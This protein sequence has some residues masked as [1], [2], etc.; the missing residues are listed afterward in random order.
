VLPCYDVPICH[1][2]RQRV[3]TVDGT[4]VAQY[5]VIV[6]SASA[7]IL[8][9]DLKKNDGPGRFWTGDLRHV[10]TEVFGA[11]EAFSVGLLETTTRKASAPSCAV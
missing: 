11:F 7:F 8:A 10:K 2:S 3:I 1:D 9:S 6:S 4:N 5:L